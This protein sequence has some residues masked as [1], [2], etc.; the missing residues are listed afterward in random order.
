MVRVNWVDLWHREA[1]CHTIPL[2][3]NNSPIEAI[4][5]SSKYSSWEL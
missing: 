4:N 1:D 3:F 2:I 5:T